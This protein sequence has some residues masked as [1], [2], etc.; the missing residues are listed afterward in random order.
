MEAP[1]NNLLS[2]V[3]QLCSVPMAAKT[4]RFADRDRSMPCRVKQQRADAPPSSSHSNPVHFDLGS[5]FDTSGTRDSAASFAWVLVLSYEGL[6]KGFDLA[7][8]GVSDLMHSRQAV[9][10]WPA[11]HPHMHARAVARVR[12][13]AVTSTTSLAACRDLRLAVRRHPAAHGLISTP[14]RPEGCVAARDAR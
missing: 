5:A 12:Y 10:V 4:F 13:Q 9:E 7:H 3:R 8:V 2:A 6:S 1:D 14:K 11:A